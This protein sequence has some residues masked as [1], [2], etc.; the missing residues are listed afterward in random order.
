VAIHVKCPNPACGKEFDLNSDLAGKTVKCDT[1]QK[2]FQVPV[3]AKT[4][5]P[6]DP[7]IGTKIAHYRIESLLGQGGMGRV[8][9]A[10]NTSL[11]KTCAIKVLPQEFSKQEQ[12]AID[13]FIR[14]A[15]SAAKVEPPRLS[16]HSEQG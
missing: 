14:E 16:E 5:K 3:P 9:K 10:H 11:D 7:L 6:A 1:C 15:R 13:R 8:Y 12:T 2:T 4:A